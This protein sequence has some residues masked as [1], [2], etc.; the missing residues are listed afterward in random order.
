MYSIVNALLWLL[1]LTVLIWPLFWV[2]KR[3]YRT[4]RD[5]FLPESWGSTFWDGA[6]LFAAAWF[7]YG[8][9]IDKEPVK[10][11]MIFCAYGFWF[12]NAK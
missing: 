8:G 3:V 12:G 2:E 5:S 7:A 4:G 10:A 9:L 6:I 1:T 11:I